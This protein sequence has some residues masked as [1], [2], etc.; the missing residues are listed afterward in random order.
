MA[1]TFGLSKLPSLTLVAALA[2]GGVLHAEIFAAAP[3]AA[4]TGRPARPSQGSVEDLA[5]LLVGA[6]SSQAQALRDPENFKDISLRMVRIWPQR[7]DGP[8][9]YVEQAVASQVDR[10]YRQRVYHLV[11]RPDGSVASEVYTLPDPPL[12]FAGAWRTATP[13][14][15][16]DPARLAPRT[17]C[18]VIMRPG[19]DA[20]WAGA[21]ADRDCPSELH[22]ASYAT[23]QVTLT[24]Q[25]LDSWDRG[26]DAAGQQI[27]GATTGPYHFVRLKP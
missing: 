23:S 18:A 9:L 6:Y 12:S 13:L 25:T 19:P 15:A 22:G 3:A 20:S 16:L 8:W 7:T 21:T 5:K 10:P 4:H 14:D 27:W 24:S 1:T 11:P 2:V 17:G 26:Y